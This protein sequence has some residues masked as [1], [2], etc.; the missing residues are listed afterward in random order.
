M[1]KFV[2]GLGILAGLG[3]ALI[4]EAS[5]ANKRDEIKNHPTESGHKNKDC[6]SQPKPRSESAENHSLFVQEI[7][8]LDLSCTCTDT[9]YCGN[10]LACYGGCGGECNT[11]SSS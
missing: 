1:K 8:H 5:V 7:K 6:K 9:C 3:L 10:C 2:E 4:Y 11:C